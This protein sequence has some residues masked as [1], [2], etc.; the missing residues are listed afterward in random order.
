ME[1]TAV[2]VY[3]CWR[4]RGGSGVGEGKR[5]QRAENLIAI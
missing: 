5:D 1:N 4:V 2:L 3:R